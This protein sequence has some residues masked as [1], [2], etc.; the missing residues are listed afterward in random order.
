MN[1]LKSE[2]PICPV[3]THLSYLANS[4]IIYNY[5]RASPV[6]RQHRVLL[7]LRRSFDIVPEITSDSSKF[8]KL[9]E[10]LTLKREASLEYN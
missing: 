1:D 7:N 5:K 10:D 4:N 3:K 9:S 8:G 2:E 6:L